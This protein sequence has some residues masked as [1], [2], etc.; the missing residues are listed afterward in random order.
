MG[1][2]M[3]LRKRIYIAA[4]YEHRNVVA[5][6]EITIAGREV[7][8]DPKKIYEIVE[9]VGYWR[10]ANAVHNWFVT[11]VQGGKDECQESDVSIQDLKKLKAI[12]E[13]VLLTKD[14]SA[15]PPTGGFFFGSTEIDAGYFQDLEHTIEILKDLDPES[16][17]SYRASW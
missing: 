15:L 6:V 4:E 3:Y 17:Y 9:S 12:C 1:L 11:N 8:I 7:K 14:A 2:D 13:N 10:K 16:E 5:K